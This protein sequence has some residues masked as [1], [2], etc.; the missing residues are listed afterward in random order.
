VQRQLRRAGST[1]QGQINPEFSGI[2]GIGAFHL[3]TGGIE[4]LE[5]AASHV[6]ERQ[7]AQARKQHIAAIVLFE[8]TYETMELKGPGGA[9]MITLMPVMRNRMVR[10][11]GYRG[12]LQIAQH[13]VTG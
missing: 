8:M 13:A 3:G 12:D 2:V 6:L 11:P 4:V 10:H 9:S 7:Q 5:A 1:G